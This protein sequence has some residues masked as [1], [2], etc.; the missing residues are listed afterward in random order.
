MIIPTSDGK[1]WVRITHFSAQRKMA[2][3]AMAKG[4]HTKAEFHYKLSRTV[5]RK[6]R[7]MLIFPKVLT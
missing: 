3:V 6:R 4:D 2:R 5:R 1:G 7:R